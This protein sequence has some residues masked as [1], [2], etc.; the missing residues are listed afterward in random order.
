[1]LKNLIFKGCRYNLSLDYILY[2]ITFSEV[3]LFYENVIK[4]NYMLI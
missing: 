2:I 1:M 3:H 4:R